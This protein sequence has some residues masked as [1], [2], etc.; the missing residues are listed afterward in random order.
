M[1]IG[2]AIRKWL[3]TDPIADNLH[4]V[5]S[6]VRGL[7]EDEWR[8]LEIIERRRKAGYSLEIYSKRLDEMAG[9]IQRSLAW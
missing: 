3:A 6:N 4:Y 2:G 8:L 9:R 1:N 7:S 5:R